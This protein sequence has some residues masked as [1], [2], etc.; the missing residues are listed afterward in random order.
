MCNKMVTMFMQINLP[1][2]SHGCV[3]VCAWMFVC[4]VCIIYVCACVCAYVLCM[5]MHVYLKSILSS[6][7][8]RQY[9]RI[10]HTVCIRSY[11]MYFVL[12]FFVCLSLFWLFLFFKTG[13]ICETV[14]AAGLY[15]PRAGIRGL[16]HSTGLF[17]SS[18]PL[19]W[20]PLPPFLPTIHNMPLVFALLFWL[21]IFNLFPYW[22]IIWK[23]ATFFPLCVSFI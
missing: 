10:S 15:L 13:F 7:T 8:Q 11:F 3:C 1:I 20:V 5:C 21:Y 16:H 22:V 4:A 12:F 23:L 18:Y 19:T 6:K 9:I 2:I 14:L 17:C